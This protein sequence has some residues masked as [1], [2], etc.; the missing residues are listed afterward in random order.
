MSNGTGPVR[1]TPIRPFR[2]RRQGSIDMDD[3]NGDHFSSRA[4]THSHTDLRAMSRTSSIL[5]LSGLAERSSA[6]FGIFEQGGGYE[7]EPAT[8]ELGGGARRYELRSTARADDEAKRRLDEQEAAQLRLTEHLQNALRMAII[9]GTSYIF[10]LLFN[11][12]PAKNKFCAITSAQN[13]S[14]VL[15]C[16][17]AT[18]TAIIF[19]AAVNWVSQRDR[20]DSIVDDDEEDGRDVDMK[21][22]SAELGAKTRSI[23][24][25][26]ETNLIIRWFAGFLGLAYAGTKLDYTNAWQFNG[27][28]AAVATG[29]LLVVDRTIHGFVVSILLAAVGTTVYYMAL[30]PPVDDMPGVAALVWLNVAVYGCLGKAIGLLR[31]PSRRPA[32]T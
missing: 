2:A 17:A 11:R 4:R 19:S 10:I 22:T 31:K 8:P 21:S 20:K 5:S 15:Y 24:S 18:G 12:L 3:D 16:L 7:T 26:G 30:R 32:A 6:L 13:I 28:V 29:C 9:L 1:P 25:S 27:C 14:P 23:S